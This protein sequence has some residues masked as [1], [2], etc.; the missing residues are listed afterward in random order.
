MDV[1][2]RSPGG[3]RAP[4]W[5]FKNMQAWN[6]KI[7]LQHADRLLTW[8]TLALAV[9]TPGPNHKAWYSAVLSRWVSPPIR[10]C[11]ATSTTA[12]C[13][14]ADTDRAVNET[15]HTRW[16]CL[17][18]GSC[19]RLECLASICQ[20]CFIACAV[21]PGSEDSIVHRVIWLSRLTMSSADCDCFTLNFVQCPCSSFLWQR[22]FNLFIL[23]LHYITFAPELR[24]YHNIIG[25]LYHNHES[26]PP[27]TDSSKRTCLTDS[28]VSLIFSPSILLYTHWK[29]VAVDM[30]LI[31][32]AYSACPTA[33][34]RWVDY[35]L[36]IT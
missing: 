2:R 31:V 17:P 12:V 19:T 3:P 23:T 36:P 22:H 14:D 18:G 21:P 4:I 11:W 28:V 16:P 24:N 15:R 7:G 1:D 5:K 8:A 33:K 34:I 25:P 20:G 13:C 10:R 9:K 27:Q 6:R 26:S 29:P 32:L 30:F 35:S